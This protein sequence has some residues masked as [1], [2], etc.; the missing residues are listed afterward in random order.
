M[1]LEVLNPTF[2]VALSESQKLYPDI[3]ANYTWTMKDVNAATY[4]D[5]DSLYTVMTSMAELYRDGQ[6]SGTSPTVILAQGM[7]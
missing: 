4:C 3:L 2:A 5:Q 6:L 1:G 7:A